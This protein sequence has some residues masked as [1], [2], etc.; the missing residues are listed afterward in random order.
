MPVAIVADLNLGILT[1]RQRDAVDAVTRQIKALGRTSFP[2]ERQQVVAALLVAGVELKRVTDRLETQLE[3]F[4]KT[5]R[6]RG[7]TDQEDDLW[8]QNLERLNVMLTV[9]GRAKAAI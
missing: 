1:D 4:D 9:L 8:I 6:E 2:D 7:T 5:L 3:A